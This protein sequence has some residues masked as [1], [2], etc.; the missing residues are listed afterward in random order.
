MQVKVT[1]AFVGRPDAEPLPR[2][3]A[4][5]E[6]IEGELA[7][8]ALRE[9]WGEEVVAP[10][11][12]PPS[13]GQ[14]DGSDADDPKLDDMT[15]PQLK[16]FAAEKSIDLGTADLKAEIRAVIDAALAASSAA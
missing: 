12:E 10:A 5:G 4:V 6:I 11:A 13:G 1:T 15:I 8:V 14:S 3:I 7:A 16:A 2:Q 9:E